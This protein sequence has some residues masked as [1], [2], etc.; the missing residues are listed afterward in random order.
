MFNDFL[1][2]GRDSVAQF[3]EQTTPRRVGLP[4]RRPTIG[5]R[6]LETLIRVLIS[7]FPILLLIGVWVYFMR[8]GPMAEGQKALPEY[9]RRHLELSERIAVALERIASQKG[10]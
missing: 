2:L 3:R 5:G 1:S 7:A 8:R 6:R 9:M 4:S 10:S